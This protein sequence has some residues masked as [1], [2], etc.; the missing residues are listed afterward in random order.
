MKDIVIT[1]STDTEAKVVMNTPKAK[2][3]LK[4][5]IQPSSD[6]L[7]ND[8]VMANNELSKILAWAISHNLTIESNVRI[9]IKPL[10]T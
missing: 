8:G 1:K 7:P 6:Q 10:N 2:R 4:K 3:I 9:T 5:N